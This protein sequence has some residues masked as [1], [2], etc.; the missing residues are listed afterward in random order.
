MMNLI[1]KKILQPN[2]GVAPLKEV[3]AR[4]QFRKNQLQALTKAISRLMLT[5][6]PAT[7]R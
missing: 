1:H 7:D 6:T 5:A 4:N 3:T 2:H